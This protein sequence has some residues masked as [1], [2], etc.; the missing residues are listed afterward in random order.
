MNSDTIFHQQSEPK[1]G[2]AVA[3]NGGTP[4]PQHPQFS[5][6]RYTSAFFATSLNAKEVTQPEF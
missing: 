1:L 3:Q 6:R 5:V 4:E 2:G